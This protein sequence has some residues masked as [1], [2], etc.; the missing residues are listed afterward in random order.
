MPDPQNRQQM[1]A[2]ELAQE[3]Q[4]VLRLPAPR[5]TVNLTVGLKELIVGLLALGG[6]ALLLATLFLAAKNHFEKQ[7]YGFYL[8]K[9]SFILNRLAEFL[10]R[11]G[12]GAP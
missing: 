1:T 10:S 4:E 3:Y 12:Q 11:N 8:E 9:G 7:K 5:E 2:E 6:G